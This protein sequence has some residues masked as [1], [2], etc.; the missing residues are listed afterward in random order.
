MKLLN[1]GFLCL[2]LSLCAAPI[3]AQIVPHTKDV[4]VKKPELFRDLPKRMDV[5][6]QA[7]APLLQK[8][9]GERVTVSLASGFLFSGVVVSKSSAA[10]VRY[11]TVVL[12]DAN[13]PGAAFTVTGVRKPDGTY[14]YSGRLLSLQHSDAFE[15][16]EERGQL[17][18]EK[19]E[20]DELVSE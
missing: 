13:R 14:R 12:K 17:A 15:L 4:T 16:V 1:T 8:E 19:K 6:A 2:L 5:N 18:L 10:E 7:L 3:A 11:K 9:V 20:L